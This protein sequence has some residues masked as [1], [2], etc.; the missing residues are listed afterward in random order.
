MGPAKKS[1]ILDH[2]QHRMRKRGVKD[3]IREIEKNNNEL[4]EKR[5]NE[6]K[7]VKSPPFNMIELNKVLK[8]LKT[9]KSKDHENYVCELFKPCVIGSDLKN[10]ILIMMNHMKNHTWISECLRTSHITILHKKGCK[11]DLNNW[12]G[13]FVSSVLRTILMKLIYGRTYDKV[14]SNMTDSQIGARK[15][16][17]V[18]NHLFVLNTIISDVTSSKKK[19]PIDLNIMDFKQ[20]FD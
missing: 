18:R 15:N 12:R 7:K 2:F 3:E 10:S 11:L 16:K 6:T 14:S 8:S 4:F 20:M 13:I 5:L 17:S 1:V 9:G 19:K